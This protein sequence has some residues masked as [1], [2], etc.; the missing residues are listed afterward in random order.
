MQNEYKYITQEKS[1][2]NFDVFFSISHVFANFEVSNVEF[3]LKGIWNYVEITS[4]R[5]RDVEITG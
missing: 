5:D 2:V 1:L 3:F 4:R